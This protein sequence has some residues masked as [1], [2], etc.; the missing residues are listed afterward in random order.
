MKKIKIIL[1][2][3]ALLVIAA[4]TNFSCDPPKDDCDGKGTLSIENKSL[5]TVQ[6]L[7]ID[8]VNYGSVDP[9]DKKEAKLAPGTHSWQMA[10]I[11]GGTGCSA[12]TV[13]IVACQ[14]S[15]F[16]CSAK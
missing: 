6:R 10:G 12:A 9:G 5:S 11:S 1:I 3:I 4:S 2:V 13:I 16:S 15:S 7:M 14:T 8:G